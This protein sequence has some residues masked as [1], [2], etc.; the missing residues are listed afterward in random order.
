MNYTISDPNKER[1]IKITSSIIGFRSN[2]TKVRCFFEKEYV[3]P[4]ADHLRD[5]RI[6]AEDV[7]I[8]D[9]TPSGVI[10]IEFI[11]DVPSEKMQLLRIKGAFITFLEKKIAQ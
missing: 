9:S 10:I 3:L 11:G 4:F 7:T 6:P 5:L 8:S 2:R 1:S